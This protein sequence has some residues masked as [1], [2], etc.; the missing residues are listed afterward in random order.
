M[1]DSVASS[2]WT[3]GT[4]QENGQTVTID[5]SES[6]SFDQILLNSSGSSNDY[7]RSFTVFV[8]SNG[9]DWGSAQVSGSGEGAITSIEFPVQTQRYIRISQTGS[10]ANFGWPID[11]LEIFA[12]QIEQPPA[13]ETPGSDSDVIKYIAPVIS[14]LLAPESDTTKTDSL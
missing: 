5:L 12:D 13:L 6:L 8:S 1:I 3:T 10:S 11:E 4:P 9:S 7:T 14:T 2:R